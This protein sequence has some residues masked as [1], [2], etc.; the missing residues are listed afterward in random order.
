MNI[1]D[2]FIAKA[3]DNPARIVYPKRLI[4]VSWKLQRR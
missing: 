3:Q 4:H 2:M 1:V